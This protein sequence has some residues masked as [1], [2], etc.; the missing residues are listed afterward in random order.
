MLRK[1]ITLS[2][3]TSVDDRLNTYWYLLGTKLEHR[4]ALTLLAVYPGLESPD[5]L[6]QF[7]DDARDLIKTGAQGI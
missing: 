1:G 7:D 5:L 2:S 6:F 3:T 4:T